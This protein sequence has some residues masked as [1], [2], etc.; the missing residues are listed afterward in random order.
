MQEGLITG[1]VTALVFALIYLMGMVA[2]GG[3]K[4]GSTQTV[5]RYGGFFR[6]LGLLCAAIA[7]LSLVGGVADE[8]T[9][10]MG[11]RDGKFNPIWLLAGL[12]TVL[13]LPILVE[14][15]TRQLTLTEEGMI[16]RSWLGTGTLIRWEYIRKIDNVPMASKYYVQIVGS[17]IAVSHYLAGLDVFVNECKKHLDPKVYGEAFGTRKGGMKYEPRK[18]GANDNPFDFGDKR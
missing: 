5:L 16:P 1:L 6:G 11:P 10:W 18:P 12:F 8:L 2:G 13:G 14:V 7:V 17:R 3:V 15:K 4:K 9:H